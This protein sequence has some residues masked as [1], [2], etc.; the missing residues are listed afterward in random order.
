MKES[1]QMINNMDRVKKFGQMAQY[2]KDSLLMVRNPDKA[3]SAGMISL[4]TSGS[5]KIM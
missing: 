5:F 3:L 4:S 1:G 2:L